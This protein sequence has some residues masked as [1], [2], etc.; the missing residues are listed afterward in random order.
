MAFLS[1][2]PSFL[3][4]LPSCCTSSTSMSSSSCDILLSELRRKTFASSFFQREKTALSGVK[5][6]MRTCRIGAENMAQVSAQS[7]AMLLGEISP[8]I[9]TTTVTTTVEIVAPASP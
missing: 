4:M 5:T 1:S 9:S 8:K 6:Q 7:L 2:S 3:S